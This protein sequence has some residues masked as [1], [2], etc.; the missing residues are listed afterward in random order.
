MSTIDITKKYTTRSGLPVRVYATDGMGLYPVHGAINY[1]DGWDNSTW[2]AN[3]AYTEGATEGSRSLVPVKTWRVWRK[4]DAV[5]KYIMI[6]N[7]R[8]GSLTACCISVL[9]E[10]SILEDLFN[11]FVWVHP[12]GVETPCGV[13]E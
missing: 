6:R 10:S 3:G 1:G 12:S 4:E 13:E 11:R 9:D 5:P 7:K 8:D 2:C